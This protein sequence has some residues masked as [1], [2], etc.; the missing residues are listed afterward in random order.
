MAAKTSKSQ[1]REIEFE[2]SSGNV[3]ADLELPNPEERLTKAMLAIR[4]AELI[5]S[6]GLNQVQAAARLGI[7]QPK[8]SNLLRG[9][10]R[11]FSTDRL[12]AFLNALDCD[13]IIT[14]RPAKKNRSASV[15]VLAG[16]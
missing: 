1:S 12:M 8:I 2:I 11:G 10:L 14:I 15:H 3:F 9:H 5:E 6:L 7:D 13:V 4:I 16:A